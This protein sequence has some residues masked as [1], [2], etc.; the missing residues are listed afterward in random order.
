MDG[1]ESNDDPFVSGR[2]SLSIYTLK[3]VALPRLISK[4]GKRFP[5]FPRL[6][7]ST[8]P[9]NATM[10]HRGTWMVCRNDD[11][12]RWL[13]LKLP[14]VRSSPCFAKRCCIAGT[15]RVPLPGPLD[16]PFHRTSYDPTPSRFVHSSFARVDFLMPSG[17]R[18]L[19]PFA[20]ASCRSS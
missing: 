7:L 9:S 15:S 6:K 11:G 13:L 5:R 14:A 16:S 10:Q 18:S 3:L 12:T 19:W 20:A 17:T 8:T 1:V 4:Y 2:N